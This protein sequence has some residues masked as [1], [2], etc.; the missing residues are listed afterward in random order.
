MNTKLT[1]RLDDELI[2]HAKHYAKLQHKSVSQ[3]V[4]EYFLQLKMIQQKSEQQ[5]I[6]SITQQLS[7]I[8]A[9]TNLTDDKADYYDYLEKKHQ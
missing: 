6:P 5:P 4:A 1:L 3:I 7:G 8:L 2:Q 9:D